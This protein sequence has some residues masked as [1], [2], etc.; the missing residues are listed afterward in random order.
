VAQAS[1]AASSSPP[2]K[3]G[4]L[5]GEKAMALLRRYGIPLV[6]GRL[7]DKEDGA[8]AAAKE[9]GYPV[10]LKIISSQWAHKSDLGG[11][12]LNIAGE[13]ELRKAYGELMG[14]F[15]RQTPGGY[16]QGI[17]VQKQVQGTELL[18][19]IKKDPQFGTVVVAGMGGIYTEIFQDIARAFAPVSREAAVAMLQSLKM[20]PILKGV[21][22]QPGVHLACLEDLILALS[23]LAE[24]HPEIAEMDLNPIV[25]DAKGCWCV[26][27]RAVV[28]ERKRV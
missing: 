19:G 1:P 6:P 17:L 5:V 10:V 27:C 15:S 23:R 16:L 28:E 14:L 12:I 4:L 13:S 7:V 22:G 25:A 24:D 8:V 20:Y 18:F 21:R 26:D 9:I 3:A 11:V 2:L